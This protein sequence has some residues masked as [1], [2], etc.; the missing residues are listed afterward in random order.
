[1][2]LLIGGFKHELSSF[3]DG[4]TTL[5]DIANQGFVVDGAAM[6]GPATGSRMEHH[7]AAAYAA[8][9]GIELVPSLEA[10]GG[11]GPRLTDET[12]DG[13]A[14]SILAVA[15]R[16]AGRIDGV[17]LTLHGATA[18]ASLDDAEGD[19]AG[20]LRRVVGDIPIAASFD[21]HGNL[22]DAMVHDLDAIVA[23]RTCPHTDYY[24]TGL[25]TME[26]L[27]RAVAGEIR[28]RTVQRKLRLGASAERHDTTSGPMVE[29]M[30]LARQAEQAPEI[31]AVSV[32]AT[33][34]WMDVA[35]Y[36]WSVVVVTN[37]DLAAGQAVADEIGAQI[38]EWRDRFLVHKT[39]V[40]DALAA[41]AATIGRPVV[42]AEGSDSPS[43]GANGDGNDL[44][45]HLVGGSFTG[46]ALLTVTDPP[47]AASCAA[48]GV[49]AQLD[50]TL[51]G[52]LTP[53]FFEPL[54]LTATVMKVTD[55]RF[56][57]VNPDRPI[58]LG[59][60]AL[61]RHGET[62]IVVTTRPAWHLD[63][64]VY[65]HMGLEP[66][67]FDVVLAKS[68]GAY[69]AIYDPISALTMELDVVGPCDSDL[70]RLPFQRIP[71][72]LWPF[73]PELAEPWHR[74]GIDDIGE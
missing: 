35:E 4:R 45:R 72:P 37:D 2:R 47:A 27:H 34:P 18:T 10:W 11:A 60:S 49:G 58:D 55:G 19:F 38:W 51:G 74:G 21:L 66:A 43:A 46:T 52:R 40:K 25:R 16:E 41:A 31:L 57:L 59:P 12:Y 67:D 23:F 50:L 3:V 22:T 24:E 7:A 39:S 5:A 28:P 13:I 9:H 36:G 54:A 20:R 71:R 70:T 26:L 29:V 65:Q 61:V 48:A 64:S 17:Y 42:L 69:R 63:A 44:L 73:D 14:E 53:D 56:R 15:R 32:F 6:F 68:A 1:M 30:A 62:S 8:E 33:Q